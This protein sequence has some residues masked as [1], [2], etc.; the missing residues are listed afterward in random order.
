MGRI[1]GNEIFITES[2]KIY[3]DGSIS[4]FSRVYNHTKMVLLEVSD[5]E[6]VWKETADEI[7]KEIPSP[8]FSISINCFSRTKLFEKE[9]KLY[10]FI[11][12]LKANYGD[13]I[14]LS[15]FGE[16]LGFIH[17]NQSMVIAVFE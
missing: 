5:F 7:H 14:G 1:V 13:F 16:Q 2:N 12:M 9:N 10:H 11:S 4:Y 6:T 15:G 8:S 3:S 17:L